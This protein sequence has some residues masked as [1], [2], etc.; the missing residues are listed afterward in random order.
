MTRT[1]I[2][3]LTRRL[4]RLQAGSLSTQSRPGDWPPGLAIAGRA[5]RRRRAARRGLRQPQ[6]Q[7]QPQA[8]AVAGG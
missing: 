3:L 7:P 8:E 5:A 4:N 1:R 6:P 2:L